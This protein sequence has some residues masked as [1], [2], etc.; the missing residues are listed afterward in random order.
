VL[1]EGHVLDPA[2]G[3]EGTKALV[4]FADHVQADD[5]VDNALLTVADGLLLIWK[6]RA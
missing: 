6:R 2:D 4:A 1:R 5:R 3:D